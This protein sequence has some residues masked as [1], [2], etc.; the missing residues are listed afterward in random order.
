MNTQGIISINPIGTP[1]GINKRFIHFPALCT[2]TPIA[3]K[4]TRVLKFF[5]QYLAHL[6]GRDTMLPTICAEGTRLLSFRT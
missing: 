4:R 2:S 3:G 6:S 1:S 5:F